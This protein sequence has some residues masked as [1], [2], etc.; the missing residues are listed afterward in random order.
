MPSNAVAAGNAHEGLLQPFPTPAAKDSRGA[1]TQDADGHAQGGEWGWYEA[2]ELAGVMAWLEGGCDAEQD[3]ADQIYEAYH[4]VLRPSPTLQ[5]GISSHLPSSCCCLSDVGTAPAELALT[6]GICNCPVA[7]AW[8]VQVMMLCNVPHRMRSRARQQP[9]L[10][11]LAP[12]VSRRTATGAPGCWA[13]SPTSSV[14]CANH[15]KHI[16]LHCCQP[17]GGA[18]MCT[19]APPPSH[20]PPDGDLNVT[21]PPQHLHHIGSPVACCRRS[22]S[23]C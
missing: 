17:E 16:R 4:S 9:L 11:Q 22:W 21:V 2:G 8:R 7:V 19:C 15:N 23:R 20:D 6:A 14:R 3:L 10:L 12:R 1:S 18:C 13:A 5:V